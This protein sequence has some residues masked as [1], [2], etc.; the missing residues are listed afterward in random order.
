ML[1]Y[2]IAE[3]RSRTLAERLHDLYRIHLPDEF[4]QHG[5]LVAGPG[6]DLEYDMFRPRIDQVRRQRDDVWLRDRLPL[7][8]RQRM[9][10][11][12][13]AYGALGDE[14]MT[15]H[16]AHRVHHAAGET[17]AAGFLPRRSRH[18][19]DLGDHLAP[20]AR[21]RFVARGGAL[22]RS[23]QGRYERRDH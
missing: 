13:T 12:R 20:L 23:E 14:S 16:F 3:R 6:A 4:A 21:E 18:R 8:D 5:S 1:P 11:I 19:C 10:A 17:L 9:V 22:Q 7:A 15:R 2:P